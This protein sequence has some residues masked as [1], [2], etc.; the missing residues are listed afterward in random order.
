MLDIEHKTLEYIKQKLDCIHEIEDLKEWESIFLED[1]YID[2][3]LPYG[4]QKDYYELASL[5]MHQSN[6]NQIYSTL[7]GL[8]SQSTDQFSLRC[9]YAAISDFLNRFFKPIY[10]VYL[11]DQLLYFLEKEPFL[12]TDFK[13]FFSE[14]VKTNSY[15]EQIL[16]GF[17]YQFSM[18][19]ISMIDERFL[20][21]FYYLKKEYETKLS[22][23][24]FQ[25]KV[26]YFNQ[27]LEDYIFNTEEGMNNFYAHQLYL[28]LN[29]LLSRKDRARPRKR[30]KE[31]D[32]AQLTL[33]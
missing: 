12:N 13:H 2:N 18:S 16:F 19:T 17:D 20:N 25:E 9:A 29:Q 4:K 15:Y 6:K 26:S 14:G 21:S 8:A 30:K 32:S 22:S 23:Q 3:W 24:K 33:F 7:L 27:A 31:S 1:T 10:E 28:V 5:I 11:Y